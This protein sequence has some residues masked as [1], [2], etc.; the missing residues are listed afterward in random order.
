MKLNTIALLGLFS[1]I[2]LPVAAVDSHCNEQEQIIFSCSL[3]KNIVSV[4]GSKNISQNSG[5]LQYRFGQK[6]A[7]ELIFPASTEPSHHVD[8]QARTLMF[9]GGGGAYLRFIN[10]QYHYVIYTAIGKGW[11][12]KDGVSVEKDGKR[13]ADLKCRDIPISKLGDD[14]FTRAGLM[15]DK[16]EFLPP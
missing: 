15:S 8:I 12:T 6:N 16:E 5:Y 14:F 13:I 1:L 11:G 2:S 9:S 7:P 4:C 3:G 10:G